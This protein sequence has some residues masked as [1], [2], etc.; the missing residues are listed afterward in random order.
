MDVLNCVNTIKDVDFYL[1]DVYEF[2]N[3]LQSKHP[4]NNNIKAKIRQQL[5]ILRDMGFVVFL[6]TDITEKIILRYRPL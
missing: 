4:N 5:Q 1:S 3:V 6:A 2:A